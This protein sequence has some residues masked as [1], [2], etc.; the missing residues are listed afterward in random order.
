M[1]NKEIA[2]VFTDIACLLEMKEENIF[3]IRAYRKVAFTIEQLS[4][5]LAV[6]VQ[7]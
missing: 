4:E 1:N 7:R 2:K 3:K 5:E 6:I